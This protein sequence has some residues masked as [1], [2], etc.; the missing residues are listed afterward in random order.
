MSGFEVSAFPPQQKI[1]ERSNIVRE[2]SLVRRLEVW[3]VILIMV[4]TLQVFAEGQQDSVQPNEKVTLV[5]INS[6][7]VNRAAGEGKVFE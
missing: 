7:G 3:L 4:G 2:V 6:P 5:W 1:D